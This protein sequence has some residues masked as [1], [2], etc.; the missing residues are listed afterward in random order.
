MKTIR[1]AINNPGLI[2]FFIQ[3]IFELRITLKRDFIGYLFLSFSLIAISS[4]KFRILSSNCDIRID[5]KKQRTNNKKIVNKNIKFTGDKKPIN[6]EIHET[7]FGKMLN[8]IKII[9][10]PIQKMVSHIWI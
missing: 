4:T 8:N 5:S 2:H 7:P 6:S 10:I 9:D 3:V 1:K